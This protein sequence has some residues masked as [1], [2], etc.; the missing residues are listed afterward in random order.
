VTIGKLPRLIAASVFGVGL[1]A[2]LAAQAV[3]STSTKSAPELAVAAF[4]ANGLAHETLA[5]SIFAG[6]VSKATAAA[7]EGGE[8]NPAL[9]A[10]A[11]AA[12]PISNDISQAAA[13]LAAGSALQAVRLDPLSP[14][15]HAF[16]A[17]GQAESGNRDAILEAANA[18]N[19]RDLTLQSLQLQK[20]IGAADYSK[21]ITTLDQLLRVHPEYSSEFFPVLVTAL[22]NEDTIPLFAQMLDGS[23]PWHQK[24]LTF[25]VRD[26]S[27]LSNLASL[28]P[29]ISSADYDFDRRLIIYL[30]DQG[31]V[32]TAAS[33]YGLVSGS[34]SRDSQ[35]DGLLDWK[36][37]YPPFEWRFIDQPG[38]RAQASRAG[39]EIEL[40]VRPGKGG[41][42]AGRLLPA[43]TA[44]FSVRIEHDVRPA[45]MREDV[46]VQLICSDSAQIVLNKKLGGE[47]SVFPV[48]ALPDGCDYVA[49]SITARAWTGRSALRGTIQQISIR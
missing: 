8:A 14:R 18:L 49:L 34:E 10:T 22:A 11:G 40:F 21:T 31:D 28:R 13:R 43:P 42:I 48:A 16:L 23:A 41:L 46:G 4:P 19:R 15:A 1:S 2:L 37:E 32:E 24:F 7:N 12:A 30:V 44:P 47:S 35:T 3:S 45:S 36:A 33:I 39:D 27:A 9:P 25:A 38:F 20:H 5:A 29:D 26:R 6:S 17:L